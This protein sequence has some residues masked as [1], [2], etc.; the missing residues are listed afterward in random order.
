MNT[1]TPLTSVSYSY[2]KSGLSVSVS[3]TLISSNK[4]HLKIT[5]NDSH[6]TALDSNQNVI[7]SENRY[8][9][10]FV[11][12]INKSIV[13]A[14]MTSEELQFNEEKIPVLSDIPVI[15]ALFKRDSKNLKKSTYIFKLRVLFD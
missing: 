7:T 15:R 9:S 5:F 4:V 14:G 12:D 6:I 3:P 10:D 13:I 11:V 2:I 1:T 8:S